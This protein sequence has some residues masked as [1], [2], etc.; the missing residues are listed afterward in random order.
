MSADSSLLSLPPDLL[1]CILGALGTRA[2]VNA[3]ATCKALH[4]LAAELPLRPVMTSSTQP[5]MQQWL[6]SPAVA[7]RVVSL[8]ARTC[9]WG[10]C[11]FVGALRN[12]RVLV[13]TFGHV[14]PQMC[15]W[16]PP[17]LEFL[18]IHRLACNHMDT[19]LFSTKRLAHLPRLRTLKLTF[20]PGWDV[21]VVERLG[22]HRFEHLSIRKA[23]TLVVRCPLRAATLHLEGLVDLV[24]P[25][26]LEAERL[27]LECPRESAAFDVMVSPQTAPLLRE[28]RLACPGRVTV[29]WLAHMDLEELHVRY[30]SV[31]V[32]C[33]VMAGMP[34]LRRMEMHTRFGVAV[35]GHTPLPRHVR[36]S[37]YVAGVPLPPRAVDAMFFDRRATDE[38]LSN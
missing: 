10:R 34:R 27:A 11:C 6:G 1:R 21:V 5:R 7:P 35:S 28:L 3:S 24:C 12:L 38:W 26:A 8:T 4:A 13:V 37:A 25:F 20:T 32:P 15:K 33:A 9:M 18:D 2:L 23:P 31:I 22:E 16:L 19:D 36:I 29:P 17:T 30:D 14:A